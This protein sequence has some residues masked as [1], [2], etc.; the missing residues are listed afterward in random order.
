[1][2][3]QKLFI[4]STL[5]YTNGD[6][7]CFEQVPAVVLP[8]T[9]STTILGVGL[10]VLALH[11]LRK[12]LLTRAHGFRSTHPLHLFFLLLAVSSLG[13]SACQL[14]LQSVCYF[15]V[16]RAPADVETTG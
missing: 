7:Y 3:R 8:V 15:E 6:F 4:L 5:P 2:Q 1:M 16:W 9:I 13:L 14:F 10:S 11:H 12:Q